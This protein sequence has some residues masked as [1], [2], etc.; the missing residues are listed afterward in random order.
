MSS[1]SRI[2]NAIFLT[3]SYKLSH[4]NFEVKGVSEIYSNATPRFFKYFK[5]LYPNSDNKIVVFGIQYIIQRILID[6]WNDGFFNQSKDKVIK[7][8]KRLL[9][10]YIGMENLSH[11]EKLHDLG[12][13]PLE[14]KS[15][16]EGSLVTAGIPIFTI[17]ST[18]PDFEWLPNYLE[19]ILS[20]ELWKPLTI[21]NVGRQFRLLSNE[22]ALLTTGS[23]NGTEFQNHDFSL[24]GQSGWESASAIGVG[25]L[26]SSWGTDNVPA[27]WAAEEYYK[28]NIDKEVVGL[29]VSAGEHS[30]TTLGI[31]VMGGEDRQKGEKEYLSWLMRERFPKGILSY[32]AD[33]YDY[34]N[35]VTQI[36]PELKDQI[37]GREGKLVIRGDSGDPVEII[38][39][40]PTIIESQLKEAMQSYENDVFKPIFI[41]GVQRN[42]HELQDKY[43]LL[44]ED[45]K[46]FRFEIEIDYYNSDCD[47]VRNIC[48]SLG[49]CVS[50]HEAKG[51]IECLWDIFGG[52]INEKG[53]KVLDEH[54]GMIYGDGITMERAKDIFERL[55]AKGFAS[56]NIVFGVGLI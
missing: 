41:D 44:T 7:Q 50:T 40:I 35:V 1:P 10:Q 24:R 17:R 11:F 51:T 16:A 54:I 12:Y 55:E 28:A 14:L 9:S 23:I 8:A 39:G 20:T 22:Y 34:W 46:C 4:I 26:L 38:A 3:D 43:V 53:Y 48:F 52:T 19:S 37:M 31:T 29:S 42:I 2:I 33:S 5:A 15:L 47:S 18:H 36:L 27:I 30:V 13:L 56:L 21:A 45:G 49:D 25:F 32:V 6:A